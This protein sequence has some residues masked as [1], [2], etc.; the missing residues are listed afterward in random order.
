MNNEQIELIEKLLDTT[1]SKQMLLHFQDYEKLFKFY[2]SHTNLISK[3]DENVFFEKHIYDSLC[4]SIFFNKYNLAQDIK[5]LDVG[6]G[7]G[8][9]SI[10]LAIIYPEMQI[11]PLD[12]IAK[13]IG[14]IELVQKELR[15]E[16]LHPLCKRA[17]DLNRDF[18]NSFDVVTSRAVAYLNTLLEYT[19]PFVKT[20][21]YF[22]AYKSKNAQEEL[23]SAKNAMEVLK[24][25][26]TEIISYNLPLENDY[27]REFLIFKKN[28]NTTKD[29]PRK[30]GMAKKNP[31]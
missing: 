22:A 12:S 9:P 20:G 7:G 25:E 2:N 18:K 30:L 13:K 24:C 19:V 1:L 3:N 27:T 15:L 6:T 23:A 8:F 29:Y 10:P 17:E 5:L 21:G 28:N 4:L 16:N 11:Y 14:F 26:L 31:L